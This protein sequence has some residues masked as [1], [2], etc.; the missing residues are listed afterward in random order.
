MEAL[1]WPRGFVC[2]RCQAREYWMG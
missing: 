2:P 1:R